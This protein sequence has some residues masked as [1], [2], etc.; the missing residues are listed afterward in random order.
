MISETVHNCLDILCYFCM[1]RLQVL[2]I[3]GFVVSITLGSNPLF[4][5][6]ELF[7]QPNNI[8]DCLKVIHVCSQKMFLMAIFLFF[9]FVTVSDGYIPIYLFCSDSLFLT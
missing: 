5:D 1:Q 6:T 2:Q 4:F 9:C 8:P 7:E 3:S